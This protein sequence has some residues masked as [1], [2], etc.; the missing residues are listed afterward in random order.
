[1]AAKPLRVSFFMANMGDGGAERVVAKLL[2]HLDRARFEPRLILVKANGPF[3]KDL[4]SDVPVHELGS[5]RLATSAPALFRA[6]RREPPDVLFAAG[7]ANVVAS[8]AHRLARSPARLVLSERNAVLRP[9]RSPAALRAE[10]QLKRWTYRR[11]D[12]VTAVSQGVADQVRDVLGVPSEKL[13]VV[14]NPIVDL[15]MIDRAGESVEHPWFHDGEPLV[16]AVGRF[17]ENKDYPTL[18][19]AFAKVRAGVPARLFVLGEGPLREFVAAEAQRLGLGDVVHLHGFDPN[20]FKYMAKAHA[21]MHASRAEG[22][23]GVHIQTMACGTPVISTDCDFGP[24]E[25]IASGEDGFLVPVGDVEQLAARTLE[26][27]RDAA[28]RTRMGAAAAVSARRFS[29]SSSL[30]LYQ[31][32]LEG[33]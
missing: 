25:V 5:K 19:R 16:L 14:F 18:L 13:S 9:D 15:S 23:P 17:V 8:V 4:P 21:L 29:T 2:V 3:M 24:R 1:M 7:G 26:V 11:A 30:G 22:L 32:A 28:L 33:R 10:I 20:P 12:L 27:L 31:A 6:L